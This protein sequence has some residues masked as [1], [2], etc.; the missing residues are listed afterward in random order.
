MVF[1]WKKDCE[2]AG[3]PLFGKIPPHVRIP[4]QETAQRVQGISG[5]RPALVQ[6]IQDFRQPGQ[7]P[8]V[9]GK[10]GRRFA[11]RRGQVLFLRF[12]PER[13][14]CLFPQF[15]QR[16]LPVFRLTARLGADHGDAG[17]E[18][19]QPNGGGSFIHL[20]TTSAG[21]LMKIKAALS[22]KHVVGKAEDLIPNRHHRP[23]SVPD[24]REIVSS[25]RILP[26]ET[27]TATGCQKPGSACADPRE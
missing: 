11:V 13:E 22:G 10:R 14:S 4:F 2:A 15:F 23:P 26:E 19:R 5:S 16:D 25:R 21:S 24:A 3:L 20:L 1:R 9:I 8:C 7:I 27:C 6:K 18:M 12:L 17:R